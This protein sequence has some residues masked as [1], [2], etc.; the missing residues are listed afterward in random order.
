[1]AFKRRVLFIETMD[2]GRLFQSRTE[3]TKKEALKEVVLAKGTD[4]GMEW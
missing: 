1:M 4:N 3:L 2:G